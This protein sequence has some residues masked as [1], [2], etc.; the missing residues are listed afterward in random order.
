MN[1]RSTGMNE[2]REFRVSEMTMIIINNDK[3]VIRGNALDLSIETIQAFDLILDTFKDA[4]G[5]KESV[6]FVNELFKIGLEI[7]TADLSPE[8][9]EE[10]PVSHD[11]VKDLVH[12]IR[13]TMPDEFKVTELRTSEATE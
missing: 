8:D 13:R 5:A 7:F 1:V 9:L 6:Y 3:A 4:V 10:E 11:T 12:T 2:G